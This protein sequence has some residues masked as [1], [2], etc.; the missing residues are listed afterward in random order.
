MEAGA[1]WT[2]QTLLYAE[3]ESLLRQPGRSL[4]KAAIS[5]IQFIPLF[6]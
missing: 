3:G 1:L 4:Q 6:E 5:V 2:G